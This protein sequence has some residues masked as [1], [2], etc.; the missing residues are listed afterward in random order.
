M[1]FCRKQE[2]P[3]ERDSSV[4]FIRQSPYKTIDT[5]TDFYSRKFV[6]K[7]KFKLRFSMIIIL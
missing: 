7:F 2:Q 3:V 5:L 6:D 4:F 1:F